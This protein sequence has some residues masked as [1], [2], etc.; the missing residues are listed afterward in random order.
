[1][2][3][4]TKGYLDEMKKMAP[5][6]VLGATSAGGGAAL[7]MI[8]AD[9]LAKDQALAAQMFRTIGQWGPLFVLVIALLVIGDRRV[10]QMLDNAKASTEAQLTAAKETAAAS[11]EMAQSQQQ[12]ADAV[13]ALVNKDDREAEKQDRMLSYVGTQMEQLIAEFHELKEKIE[14]EEETGRAA[15]A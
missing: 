12:L 9:V 7:V 8:F 15:H 14:R 3:E 4:Q 2:T 6:L 11:R 13:Q 5:P 10:G 1:M